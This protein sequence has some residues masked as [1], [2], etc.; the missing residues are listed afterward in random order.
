MTDPPMQWGYPRTVEGFWHAISRGQYDK[1]HPTDIFHDPK[2]FIMQLGLL[3]SGIAEEFNWLVLVLALI[4]LFFFLKMQKRERAWIIGVTSIYLCVGVLLVILMNPGDDKMSVDLHKV[5][6]TTSHGVVAIL[7]GYGLALT[8]ALLAVNYD[9]FRGLAPYFGAAALL[10]AFMSLYSSLSNT[11]FAG[12]NLENYDHRF[13]L[14]LLLAASFVLARLGGK[15]LFRLRDP[16]AVI[17]SD[18]MLAA[19]MFFC[20]AILCLTGAGYFAFFDVN[21]LD[22]TKLSMGTVLATIPKALA[23]KQANLP[24]LA[25]LLIMGIAVVFLAAVLLAR[26]RLPLAAVLGLFALLPVASAMSHWGSC[27]E[28]DHWFGYWFGHDMF[29]PPF[30]ASDGSLSY[31]AKQREQAM[32]GPAAT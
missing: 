12:A 27:E 2:H 17:G 5:F 18:P 13:T 24:A 25:G 4:P 19:A 15:A 20:A 6:F 1:A 32:K 21:S 7:V 30:V 10:P 23:P 9:K 26:K 22:V 11:Y 3:V 14:F 8:A 28:R 29:T 31:D 16:E